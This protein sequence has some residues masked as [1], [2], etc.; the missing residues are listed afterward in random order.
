MTLKH[1]INVSLP[2]PLAG[3]LLQICRSCLEHCY[4]IDQ[5]DYIIGNAAKTCG[6]EW[7]GTLIL[8]EKKIGSASDNHE[9]PAKK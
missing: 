9:N 4:D 6:V 2:S 5:F 1:G 8:E 3:A 7:L